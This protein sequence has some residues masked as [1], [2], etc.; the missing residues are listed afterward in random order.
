MKKI[1]FIIGLCSLTGIT[2]SQELRDANNSL[3]G[4]ISKDGSVQDKNNTTIGYF[5]N[6]GSVQDIHNKKL[7]YVLGREFLDVNHQSVGYLQKDGIVE[8]AQHTALGRID[9][10]G[11]GSV[12]DSHN[13]TIGN[14]SKVEPS[15]A[16]AYFFYF[17]F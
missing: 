8:D 2:Y 16:A 1:F 14:I 17:K 4:F 15:W 3:K 9:P 11:T 10:T 13:Q 5:K 12:K 6:D 7:G